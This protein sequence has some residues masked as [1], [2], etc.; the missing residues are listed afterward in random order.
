MLIKKDK[1][2]KTVY[3]IYAISGY[4]GKYSYALSPS[5]LDDVETNNIW[6]GSEYNQLICSIADIKEFVNEQ[7]IDLAQLRIV[8]VNDG[9]SS[10]IWQA[11]ALDKCLSI[12]SYESLIKEQ[13]MKELT[14]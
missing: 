13:I 4:D 1:N 2:G 8:L 9:F 11:N 14:H 7:R 5:A 3:T 6:P 10:H 12:E